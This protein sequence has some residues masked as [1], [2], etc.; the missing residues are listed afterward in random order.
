MYEDYFNLNDR[1]FK[2]SISPKYIYLSKKHLEILESFK[3]AVE[4]GTG[5]LMLT[6]EVGTGKTS[7]INRFVMEI[8]NDSIVAILTYGDLELIDFF[9]IL[10]AELGPAKPIF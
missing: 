4:H 1:P 5:F 7:I 3:Y 8:G 10:A 9:K 2:D 6:G